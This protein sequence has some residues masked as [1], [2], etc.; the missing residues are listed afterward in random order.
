MMEIKRKVSE[1]VVTEEGLFHKGQTPSDYEGPELTVEVVHAI[2][3]ADESGGNLMTF[4]CSAP[5][6]M[7]SSRAEVPYD[8]GQ[9]TVIDA[10]VSENFGSGTAYAHRLPQVVKEKVEGHIQLIE[11][12]GESKVLP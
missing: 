8:P 3:F 4:T 12:D 9:M 2:V 11:S 1:V 7:N 10:P 6:A 5:K